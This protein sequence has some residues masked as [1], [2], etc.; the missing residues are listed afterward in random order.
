M[1][2][3]HLLSLVL[4]SVLAVSC[5]EHGH[6]HEGEAAHGHDEG[7]AHG[8]A[9]A[10]R[11]DLSVTAYQDG[12]ELFMEYPALVVGQPSALVAHFTDAR[13]P[14]G[15]KVVTKGKVTAAL[16]YAD[17]TEER[18][19]AEKLLRD[20]IF[21]PEVRPTKSGQATLTLRLE[22]EQVAG[23]VGAGKVTVYP[24]V[25]AAVSAAPPE[26]VGESSV[27]FLKE[28]Q[29][30]TQYATAPAEVRVLQG[31][32]RANGEL[33]PVAGQAAELSAPVAGR[34]PV[35]GPVPHL[36]QVVKKG[37]VLVRVVPTTVAGAMD[38]ATVEME[39]ARARA[40]Q[41]LAEREVA[42]AEEMFSAKAIPE[43]QLDAARVAREMAIA[44]V[45]ATE[46]QLTLYRSTQSGSGGGVGGA[47]F[48]LRSPLDGVV[49][50]AEVM[51]GAVVVAG[52]RLVSVINP[53][54][55][56]L[57]AKVYEADAPKVERSPGA[58]FTVA[59]FTREFT[60]DEKSGRRVAVGSVVDSATRTVPVLFELPNPDGALKPG[61]FAK[62]TLF[63]GETVRALAV[64]E[65]AVVDDNG[66]PTVFVMEGGE[67]FFKR[68]I[69]PGVR[70]GGWVQVLDGVKEGER[71]V[72]RG[73][74]ELKLS[75]A[76]GAI[77]EHGHQ[78]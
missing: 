74:Y 70:S 73:A 7:G 9:E 50:F 20:G 41:G 76:T 44:R 30:K 33:K 4:A 22:G 75:T 68:V 53:S 67:S 27:P 10:E 42:R 16:R 47:A 40:E 37:E 38:L 60:V 39:A 28:Q 77:P 78:H 12:L 24:T 15:F 25:A 49:S 66:R 43:K 58:A 21:K 1:S 31:G 23:T 32:V 5:K 54:R 64:P 48:E 71:V 46:R 55:L 19:V 56:W 59:G 2:R 36:G 14:D 11:P 3:L 8:A 29:W 17:G 61:M 51:P 57:E 34:I 72:S 13:A 35:G 65:A 6:D 45:S 69:R 62:V 26:A 52:T 63:T 18:F